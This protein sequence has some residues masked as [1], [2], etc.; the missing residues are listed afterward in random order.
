MSNAD[1]S[2]MAVLEALQAERFVIIRAITHCLQSPR[3]VPYGRQPMCPR[4]AEDAM[5]CEVFT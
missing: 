4:R 5:G 2:G 3:V 1:R